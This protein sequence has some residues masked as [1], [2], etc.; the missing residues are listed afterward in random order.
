M[1]DRVHSGGTNELGTY[2]FY[3]RECGNVMKGTVCPNICTVCGNI[4]VDEGYGVS[5]DTT[6]GLAGDESG[7]TDKAPW[8]PVR[9]TNID[10]KLR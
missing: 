9:I 4:L 8:I 3:C 10:K 2:S 1:A 6:G 7:S 5:G